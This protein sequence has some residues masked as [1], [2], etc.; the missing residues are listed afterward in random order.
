MGYLKNLKEKWRITPEEEKEIEKLQSFIDHIKRV[1]YSG[2]ESSIMHHYQE[3]ATRAAQA[4]KELD[5]VMDKIKRRR[6][7]AVFFC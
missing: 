3:K 1:P 4:E 5:Q 2:K 6:T 7:L